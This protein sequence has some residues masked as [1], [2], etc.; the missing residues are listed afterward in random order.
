MKLLV[1][2]IL[3]ISFFRH[4]SVVSVLCPI[5]SYCPIEKASVFKVTCKV[6]KELFRTSGNHM[7][8]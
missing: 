4:I 7:H 5:D 1:C 8:E 6:I 2:L 3:E